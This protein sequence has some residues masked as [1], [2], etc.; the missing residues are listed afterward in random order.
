MSNYRIV[1]YSR[2]IDEEFETI[3]EVR[4][5]WR[6]LKL[7]SATHRYQIQVATQNWLDMTEEAAGI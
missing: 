1:N 2:S 5:A 6:V 7:F 4:A 3:E